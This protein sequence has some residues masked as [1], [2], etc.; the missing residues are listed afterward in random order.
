M[1]MAMG[2]GQLPTVDARAGAEGT[3]LDPNG[4]CRWSGVGDS[5]VTGVDDINLHVDEAAFVVVLGP[6]GPGRPRC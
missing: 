6:S 5:V 4:V 2:V 3:R 1:G